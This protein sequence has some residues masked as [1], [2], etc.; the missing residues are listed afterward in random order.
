MDLWLFLHPLNERFSNF[1]HPRFLFKSNN[2]FPEIWQFSKCNSFS[3]GCF[4]LSILLNVDSG[5]FAS[6]INHKVHNCNAL[7]KGKSN[8]SYIPW[9]LWTVYSIE[10]IPK[11]YSFFQFAFEKNSNYLKQVLP[12]PLLK[13]YLY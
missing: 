13:F 5:I 10:Y 7:R 3:P 12:L 8:V 2:S 1:C 6:F 4:L 9:T 11:V